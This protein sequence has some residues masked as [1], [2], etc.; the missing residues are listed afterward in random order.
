[1]KLIILTTI[2]YFAGEE[3]ISSTV[4]RDM[5]TCREMAVAKTYDTGEGVQEQSYCSVLVVY[6]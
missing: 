4:I 3:R 2:F 1:M 6:P 5:Q